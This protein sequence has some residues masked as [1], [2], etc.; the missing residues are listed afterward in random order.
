M[1][2]GTQI[3]ANLVPD[4]LSAAQYGASSLL[5]AQASGGNNSVKDIPRDL[6]WVKASGIRL[7]DISANRG[8]VALRSSAVRE[9]TL[10]MDTHGLSRRDRHETSV[11]LIQAAALDPSQGRPSLESGFH[12]SLGKVVLH[13]H[14]VY[15]NAFTCMEGGRDL[16][17]SATSLSFKWVKYATPGQEL[18]VELH[19]TLAAER[20]KE[21]A[22][23]VLE[24]HGFIA[25]GNSAAEVIAAAE[26]FV[27]IGKKIFGNLPRDF[28]SQQPPSV[29]LLS[30]AE[31]LSARLR[32]RWPNHVW[33]VR[34]A[35]FAAFKLAAHP[36]LFREAGPLVPDDI[37]YAERGI[38]FVT[39]PSTA[40]TLANTDDP[41]EKLAIACEGEGVLFVGRNE[42]LVTAME[43]IL[44][45]HVLVR[46]L[47]SRVGRVRP[48]PA[49]E[50]DYLQSM[51]SEKYR[52]QVSAG[53]RV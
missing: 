9:I 27:S 31:T 25:S 40:G 5:L 39:S 41:P 43:E 23:I 2:A 1:S 24:N 37:V 44:L 30:A 19:K 51:E 26:A 13:L 35:R 20:F 49:F 45:A 22:C 38:Q 21:S 15:I 12:A 18:A 36:D 47:I 48:L 33:L 52:I 3:P 17:S 14:P 53:G 8:M 10:G 34:P 16:L 46:M 4:V 28:I 7:S 11:R 29:Q 42:R 32:H 50:I 6:M